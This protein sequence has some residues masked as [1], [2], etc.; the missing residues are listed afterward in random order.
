MS[1]AAGSPPSARSAT[2]DLPMLAAFALLCLGVAA[3]GGWWTAESVGT[4]Y[5]TLRK[6][7]W[8]PPGWVFG[9]VWTLLYLMMATA[10]WLVWRRR[11]EVR[12]VLPLALFGVQLALNLAWSG[13]F[14]AMRRP[15]LGVIDIVTLWVVLAA[16]TVS[17]W[18]IRSLAG[19]LLVP[20]LLW[21]TFASALNTAIWQLNR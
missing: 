3:I 1:T 19:A 13:L 4:W 2:A 11:H 5:R 7:A 18:R 16:T 10:A 6:P 14:F 15:D 12:T 9:P 20:Y 21:V 17:F 8:T